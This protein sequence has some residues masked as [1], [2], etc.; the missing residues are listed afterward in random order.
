[1]FSSLNQKFIKFYKQ[2]LGHTGPV[3]PGHK[4]RPVPDSHGLRCKKDDHTHQ[5]Y[6]VCK[7]VNRETKIYNW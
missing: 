3:E 7:A 1:M 6:F 4:S 2:Q 5:N